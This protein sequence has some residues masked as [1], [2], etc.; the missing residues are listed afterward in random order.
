MVVVVSGGKV[1]CGVVCVVVVATWGVCEW[2]SEWGLWW[3]VCV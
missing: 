3:C 1:V 2:V